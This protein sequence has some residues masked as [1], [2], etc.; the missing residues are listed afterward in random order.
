MVRIRLKRVGRSR[1]PFFRIVVADSRSAVG[2]KY[3][4]LLGTYCPITHDLKLNK[5][6]ALLWLRRGAKPTDSVRTLLSR[7]Q[8][9]K[10]FHELRHAPVNEKVTA[11]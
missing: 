6:R 9:L 1:Q 7:Q 3:L 5:D 2:K 10:S 4:E 11:H 8:V